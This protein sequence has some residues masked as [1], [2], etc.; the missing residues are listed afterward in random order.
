M[1]RHVWNISYARE[2]KVCLR[3]GEVRDIHGNHRKAL[4][5]LAV[6]VAILVVGVVG[7]YM[8]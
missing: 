1:H 4:I 8:R 5:I 2:D 7:Y 6:S 3:C